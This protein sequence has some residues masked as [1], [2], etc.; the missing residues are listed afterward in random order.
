[1]GPT[2]SGES[3]EYRAA[4]NRLL[5]SEIE[6][7]RLAEEV[8]RARRALPP[9]GLVPEDYFFHG[10][11]PVRLSDLFEPGRSTLVLYG[12]M[13]GPEKK[14]PCHMCTPLLDGLDGVNAHLQQRF[15]FAVAE[16]RPERRRAWVRQ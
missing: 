11:G 7:R 16:S 9:G 12:Y 10:A 14:S 5:D 3:A 15:S 2:F 4:R 1:M 13:F 8:P 6:L